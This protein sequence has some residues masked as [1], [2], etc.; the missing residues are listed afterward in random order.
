M[1]CSCRHR[2]LPEFPTARGDDAQAPKGCGESFA[3]AW[4]LRERGERHTEDD[5]ALEHRAC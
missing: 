2:F 1:G 4:E 3:R 5:S